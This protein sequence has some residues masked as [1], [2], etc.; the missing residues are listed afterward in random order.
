MWQIMALDTMSLTELLARFTGILVVC[1]LHTAQASALDVC[2]AR[3]NDAIQQIYLFD[4]RPEELAFL[5]PDGAATASNV[6]TL[7]S[8]YDNGGFVTVRCA[9]KS[10]SI[11]DV[12]LKCKTNK[13]TFRKQKAGYGNLRCH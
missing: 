12:E 9:Y 2:P 6:Y 8:I 7:R 5:A 10:G 1:L 4:G 3:P 11:V 13:C